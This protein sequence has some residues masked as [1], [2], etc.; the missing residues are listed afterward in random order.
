MNK[1]N[2]SFLH[3]QRAEFSFDQTDS[4]ISKIEEKTIMTLR[5]KQNGKGLLFFE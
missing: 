1:T 5:K 2:E 4:I 3:F